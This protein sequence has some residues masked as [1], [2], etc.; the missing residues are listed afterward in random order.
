MKRE[1]EVLEEGSEEGAV[2]VWGDVLCALV[3]GT[4]DSTVLVEAEGAIGES[5]GL[6]NIVFDVSEVGEVSHQSFDRA[7]IRRGVSIGGRGDLGAEEIGWNDDV[8]EC[9]GGQ[10]SA[11]FEREGGYFVWLDGEL[12]IELVWR[13]WLDK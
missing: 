7:D 13:W 2:V 8:I 9:S 4:A 10:L 1:F 12:M 11:I 5:E 6:E 3:D